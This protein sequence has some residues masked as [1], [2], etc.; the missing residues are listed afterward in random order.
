MGYD[1]HRQGTKGW[2]EGYFRLNI[3]G[4]GWMRDV[5][6]QADP[7]LEDII[8]KFCSNDGYVVSKE[9][10]VR[11]AKALRRF[12]A[13]NPVGS[14]PK[15]RRNRAPH[16]AAAE[17]MVAGIMASLGPGG[18]VVGPEDN[19]GKPLSQDGADNI[20][21]FAEYNETQTPYEVW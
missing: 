21:A 9:E 10:G 11:I 6:L 5:M 16:E 1:M 12:L 18:A 19:I 13:D 7:E 2:D 15:R 8:Y 3:W 4:M 17:Q 20:L 14:V